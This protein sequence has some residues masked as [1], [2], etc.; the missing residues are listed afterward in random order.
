M[1]IELIKPGDV[2]WRTLL[3]NTPH[4]FY[5]LPEYIEF[6]ARFEGGEPAAFYA[7]D[8]NRKSAFLIPMLIRPMPD[9][10]H[11][12]T[13]WRDVV[14]PYGYP[15][16]ILYDSTLQSSLPE[17]LRGFMSLCREKRILSAFIRLHPLLP[18]DLEAFSQIGAVVHHGQTVWVDLKQSDDVLWG[19][20][21]KGHRQDI[22]KLEAAGFEVHH[23]H[24]EEFDTFVAMYHATM[25]ELHAAAFYRF[26]PSYFGE[27]RLALRDHLNL[28]TVVSPTGDVCAGGLFVQTDQI[29]EYHLSGSHPDYRKHAPSKLMLHA[30]RR[31]AKEVGCQFFHLGGGLGASESSLFAFKAGFSKL[32]A[33]FYT[34]RIITDQPEYQRL[35]QRRLQLC[36][37]VSDPGQ[38]FPGYRFPC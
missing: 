22:V 36:E 31:W 2:R 34:L 13:G 26:P 25:D 3:Q 7:E 19:D 5:H 10:L 20:T 37:G 8:R 38:Y 18:L 21:R 9:E 17:Y 29:V 16:P 12:E 1:K 30:V 6:T 24:W 32:R 4:D 27:M 15:S 11:D 23:N 14:T 28:F 35:T 33:E